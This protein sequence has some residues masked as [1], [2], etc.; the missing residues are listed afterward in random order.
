MEA[1]TLPGHFVFNERGEL[2]S[3]AVMNEKSRNIEFYSVKKLTFEDMGQFLKE[4]TPKP[5]AKEIP[6]KKPGA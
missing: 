1:K 3:L 2:D 5:N 6:P 4:L